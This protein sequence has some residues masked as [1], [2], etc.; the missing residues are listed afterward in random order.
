MNQNQLYIFCG[1]RAKLALCYEPLPRHARLRYSGEDIKAPM[2]VFV[3]YA[4]HV[5]MYLLPRGLLFRSLNPEPYTIN[6]E[7]LS[8]LSAY[9]VLS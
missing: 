3:G 7:P 2:S 9:V 1:L 4:G 5:T 8:V 6:R